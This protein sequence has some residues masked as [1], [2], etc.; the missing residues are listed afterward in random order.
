MVLL[1]FLLSPLLQDLVLGGKTRNI[2]DL[3]QSVGVIVFQ[4]ESGYTRLDFPGKSFPRVEGGEPLPGMP[5]YM[6]DQGKTDL[7]WSRDSSSNNMSL[8][9]FLPNV[10]A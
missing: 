2:P 9:P 5:R 10:Y 1:T 4:S 3:D 6:P 8:V 7:N